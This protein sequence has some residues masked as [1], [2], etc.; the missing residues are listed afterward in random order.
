M[1]YPGSRYLATTTYQT[2]GPNGQLVTVT[3]LPLPAPRAVVGWRQTI[4]GDRLD[5]IAYQYLSDAT[6][7]WALCDTNDAMVPAALASHPLIAIPVIAVPG[8]S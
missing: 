7:F 5:L 6:A 1:F 2:T 8:T 4:D 3:R